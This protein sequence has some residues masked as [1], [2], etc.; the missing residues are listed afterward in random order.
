MSDVDYLLPVPCNASRDAI[1]TFAENLRKESNLMNG[2]QVRELME[3]NGGKV[4][5]I[6]E[7][8]ENQKDALI[9]EPD[10]SFV[11]R[12]SKISP[13]VRNN[14]ILAHELGHYVLHWP[15]L[16]EQTP[17]VGMKCP[18]RGD[19]EDKIMMLCEQEAD[20]FAVSFLLPEHEFR[21]AIA[22]G[23]IQEA[24][25]RFAV[26]F[27]VVRQR[28]RMLGISEEPKLTV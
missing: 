5:M 26:T 6:D 14:F 18:R 28:A 21:E 1:A 11:A 16:K 7:Y 10:G 23:G 20:T 3:A 25:D 27:E 17:G 24:K 12:V 2:F 4:E 22:S 15:K 8:A 9:V 19:A 13:G